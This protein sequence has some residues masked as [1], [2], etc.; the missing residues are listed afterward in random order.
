MKTQTACWKFF[1]VPQETERASKCSNCGVQI[2]CVDKST[3]FSTTALNAHLH[4]KHSNQL[5]VEA[6]F[7]IRDI[8][9]MEN[10]TPRAQ[11][12]SMFQKVTK[13]DITVERYG[14]KSAKFTEIMRSF[15]TADSCHAC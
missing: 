3:K 11:I 1:D 12:T 9:K 8:E 15:F 6:A 7:L 13:H 10:P 4:F 14:R 2:T 5:D